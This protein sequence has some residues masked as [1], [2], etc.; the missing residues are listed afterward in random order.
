MHDVILGLRLR[1][2]G[3]GLIDYDLKR[4]F[5]WLTEKPRKGTDSDNGFAPR[6]AQLLAYSSRR[7]ASVLLL[8]EIAYSVP[9]IMQTHLPRFFNHIWVSVKRTDLYKMKIMIIFVTRVT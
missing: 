7:L 5:E 2:N 6:T 3:N 9:M 1:M 4:A 8:K